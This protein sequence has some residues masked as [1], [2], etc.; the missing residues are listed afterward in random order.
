MLGIIHEKAAI[1]CYQMR[2]GQDVRK[3]GLILFK[4]G[5][6]GGN[7]D[8]YF[9]EKGLLEVKCLA[10]HKDRLIPDAKQDL[11]VVLFD[12]DPGNK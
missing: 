7:P 1:I 9:G 12:R 11:K 8:G 6:L 4:N 3:S 5:Y 2:T 10:K